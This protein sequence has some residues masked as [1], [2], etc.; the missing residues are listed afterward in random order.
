MLSKR[1][2]NKRLVIRFP[3]LHIL[4]HKTQK[5]AANLSFSTISALYLSI[6]LETFLGDFPHSTFRREKGERKGYFS[7]AAGIHD[8]CSAGLIHALPFPKTELCA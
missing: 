8:C 3:P 1:L 4:F 6:F 7:D 2:Q 5:E